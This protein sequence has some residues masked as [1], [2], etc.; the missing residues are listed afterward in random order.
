M[1]SEKGPLS[2]AACG[3]ACMMPPKQR[4]TGSATQASE[5]STIGGVAPAAAVTGSQTSRRRAHC[6]SASAPPNSRSV[7]AHAAA[8]PVLK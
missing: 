6:A 2:F 1:T 7:C 4:S 8:S 5:R 3:A